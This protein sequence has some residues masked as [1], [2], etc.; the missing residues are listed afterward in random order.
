MTYDVFQARI[1]SGLSLGL[2]TCD[3][4]CHSTATANSRICMA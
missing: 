1:L 4:N 3:A 2:L